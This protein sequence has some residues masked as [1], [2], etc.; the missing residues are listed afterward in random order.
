ML[1]DLFFGGLGLGVGVSC[2]F[3][4]ALLWTFEIWFELVV[5]CCASG[6]LVGLL[7]V[8]VVGLLRCSGVYFGVY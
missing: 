8:G 4:F 6:L 2:F 3:L 5:A 1:W 7:S